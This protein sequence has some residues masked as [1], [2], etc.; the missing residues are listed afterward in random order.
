M[1]VNIFYS[2]I[3]YQL[4]H[5]DWQTWYETVFCVMLVTQIENPTP[6]LFSVGSLEA[7]LTTLISDK[8]GNVVVLCVV[9]WYPLDNSHYCTEWMIMGTSKVTALWILLATR[10]L[11]IQFKWTRSQISCYNTRNLALKIIKSSRDFWWCSSI[12]VA[13]WIAVEYW[14]LVL[15][16]S[17]PHTTQHIHKAQCWNGDTS[18]E[19]LLR[20]DAAVTL[21]TVILSTSA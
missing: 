10:Q 14:V 3:W 13:F 12:K 11:S 1:S 17:I 2:C 19:P 18:W 21:H 20:F 9:S 5:E 4:I 8:S 15:E 7:W 6:F 16:G